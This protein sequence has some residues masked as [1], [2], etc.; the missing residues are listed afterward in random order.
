[1]TH[2]SNRADTTTLSPDDAFAVLGNETRMEILQTLGEADVPLSFSDLRDRVGMRDSGQFNYHLDKLTGHFLGQTEEGYILQQAGR[3][4]IEAVLSGAMTNVPELEATQI[5]WRCPYCGAPV[6]VT[7]DETAPR[8]VKP[9]CTECAGIAEFSDSYDHG[10]LA[11]LRL[12]PAGIHGRTPEEILQAAITW[13]HLEDIAT[14]SDVCP[15]CSAAIEHSITVCETH[16]ASDGICEDCDRHYAAALSTRCP[17]CIFDGEEVPATLLTF[18]TIEMLAFLAT[19]GYNPIADPYGPVMKD[20][21]EEILS[22]DPFKARFT[23]I[24][25]DD[26]LSLTLDDDLSVVNA[27]NSSTPESA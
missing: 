14:C 4:V 19:H 12:P 17:N 27:T 21:D 10:Q 11:D 7:Y 15:R 24:I 22:T 2:N 6:E 26:T 1:M 20:A 9:Y 23:F 8:P 5:E 25:D 3:R 16:D 18:G 13:G